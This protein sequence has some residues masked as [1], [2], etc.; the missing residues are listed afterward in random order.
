MLLC[1]LAGSVSWLALATVVH[2]P[3]AAVGAMLLGSLSTACSDVVV[4]SLVVERARGE[5][6]VSAALLHPH[7][8]L[9]SMCAGSASCAGDAGNKGGHGV[10]RVDSKHA[11]FHMA[12]LRAGSGVIMCVLSFMFCCFPVLH[13]LCRLPLVHC[14]PC[15]GAAVL[16]V[17]S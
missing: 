3:T 11:P 17:A 9:A 8:A 2:S 14:S 6:A 1:G 16:L 10:A 4:D 5:P 15:V 12:R 13:V 7:S